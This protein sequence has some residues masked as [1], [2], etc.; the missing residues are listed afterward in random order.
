MTDPEDSGENWITSLVQGGLPQLLAGP[1]GKAISRLVGAGVEIPASFLEGIAQGIRDKSEARSEISRAIAMHAATMATADPKVMERALT[2]MLDRSYRAQKNKDAVA[3]AALKDLNDSPPPEDSEGPSEDWL[4]KFEKYAEDASGDDLRIMF[5][6]LLAGEVRKPG[7]I[8]RATLHF[9]S[10]L[11]GQTA[12]L[13]ERALPVCITHG[14]A[15]VDCLDPKMNAAEIAFVE[16]SGFWSSEKT[17]TLRFD[18][19]G[20]KLQS[21][22]EKGN[23]FA[24]RGQPDSQIKLDVAVLS[25][26]GSDL[27]KIISLPFDYQSFA[28]AILEKPGV[29]NFYFGKA[30]SSGNGVSIPYPTELFKQ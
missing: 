29:T 21:I 22:D 1:A 2:S 20:M 3:A 6:K 11:D 27:T 9:A 16:Q 23:A 7:S 10:V 12:K 28:N 25:R 26:A 17:F 5:G 13:V 18:N 24:I 15:F 14:I 4:T 8:S 19:R 30:V